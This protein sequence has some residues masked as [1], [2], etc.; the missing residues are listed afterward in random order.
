MLR[1]ILLLCW[2]LPATALGANGQRDL[3]V[4]RPGGPTPSDEASSQVSRLIVEIAKRA[5]WDPKSVQASYFNRADD[6]LAH[7]EQNTPAFL[8]ASPGFF[9]EQKTALGLRPINQI[10]INGRDTHRYYIIVRKNTLKVLDDLRGKTLAG[11]V[12]AEPEFVE[13][14]V[15]EGRFTFGTELAAEFKR[16]LSALR[17]LHRGKLDAV[18]LDE[19][20][21]AGLI[22]LPFADELTTLFT[23]PAL[24]NTGIFELTGVAARA[25]SQA[26]AEATK[27]FCSTGEGAAICETY[28]ITG[29]KP[30]PPELFDDL[31][32]RFDATAGNR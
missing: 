10:L 27:D 21:Y 23:S 20:E 7:I 2:F 6:A 31:I 13:R 24:P 15:L 1:S 29:F 9:L 5:G 25:D 12:L 14:V 16:A 30:A 8:L 28:G 19:M 4:V 3:V 11:A 32:Q 18:M 22:H 26:L 17:N